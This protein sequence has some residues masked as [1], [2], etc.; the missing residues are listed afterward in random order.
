MAKCTIISI[1]IVPNRSGLIFPWV[2][3]PC[4]VL[5][6]RGVR[7]RIHR[8][9]MCVCVVCVCACVHTQSCL[10]LCNPMDCSPPGFSVHGISQTRI[11]EQL[12]FPTPGDLPNPGVETA[13][14]ASPELTG[15][16]LSTAPSQKPI[17]CI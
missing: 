15:G 1:L 17:G 2:Q 10:T 4:N 16:V 6:W 13:S 7:G 12:P 9:C 5:S 3:A 11:L 8:V 14:P